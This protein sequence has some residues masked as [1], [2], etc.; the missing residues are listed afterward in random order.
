MK[1]IL[2]LLLICCFI[3]FAFSGCG[4]RKASEK[5]HSAP[6]P[7]P[8]ESSSLLPSEIPEPEVSP[9]PEQLPLEKKIELPEISIDKDNADS[10]QKI[11]EEIVPLAKLT[12]NYKKIV[13]DLEKKGIKTTADPKDGILF[14]SCTFSGLEYKKANG[15]FDIEQA[16]K[17]AEKE[18]KSLKNTFDS[19]VKQMGSFG[20]KNAQVCCE[21]LDTDGNIFFRE[22]ISV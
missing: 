9:T 3:S 8:P 6:T 7:I 13:S 20:I 11:L 2:P 16:T 10:N 15:T 17:T 14:F 12:D 22:I 21:A 19:L 1:K 18:I 5:Q 4:G